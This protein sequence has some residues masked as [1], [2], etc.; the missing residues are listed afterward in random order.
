MAPG[1][2]RKVGCVRTGVGGE[3]VKE[4]GDKDPPPPWDIMEPLLPLLLPLL[5]LLLKEL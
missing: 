5:L 2:L 4:A 3:A 1:W